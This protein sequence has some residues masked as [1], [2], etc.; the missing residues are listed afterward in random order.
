MAKTPSQSSSSAGLGLGLRSGEDLSTCSQLDL[1][2]GYMWLD[3]EAARGDDD[4]AKVRDELSAKMTPSRSPT[5]SGLRRW[6]P[7]A[8]VRVILSTYR[9]NLNRQLRRLK[10]IRE[11]L[12]R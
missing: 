9:C 3:L 5:G 8:H 12:E 11:N 4:A 7:A 1:V 2:L 6:K 10:R